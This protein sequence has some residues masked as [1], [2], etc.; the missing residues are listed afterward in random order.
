MLYKKYPFFSLAKITIYA[1]IHYIMNVFIDMC[2]RSCIHV[3]TSICWYI[4]NI[5]YKKVSIFFNWLPLQNIKIVFLYFITHDK[6]RLLKKIWCI[7]FFL[8]LR[9][10]KNFYCLYFHIELFL[11]YMYYTYIY[12][13]IFTVHLYFFFKQNSL[14]HFFPYPSNVN[15]ILK[16]YHSE[17]LKSSS[18]YLSKNE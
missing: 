16:F 14:Q 17:R 1:R 2:L 4:K 7:Y 11:I 6:V 3:N 13:Y 8:F 10:R 18:S 9:Y 5:Y 12:T 15:I